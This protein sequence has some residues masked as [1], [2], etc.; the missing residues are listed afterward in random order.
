MVGYPLF[1]SEVESVASSSMA[2]NAMKILAL[3]A[4]EFPRPIYVFHLVL[5]GGGR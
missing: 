3:D 5:T 2:I 1:L 4:S